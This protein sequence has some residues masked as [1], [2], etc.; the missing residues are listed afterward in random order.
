MYLYVLHACLVPME[1][2]FPLE[3]ELRVVVSH[4]VDA[5]T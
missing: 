2:W 5:G 3:L 4:H 1:H